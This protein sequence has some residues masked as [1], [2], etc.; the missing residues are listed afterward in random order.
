MNSTQKITQE[1]EDYTYKPKIE[2]IKA[3]KDWWDRQDYLGYMA[4]AYKLAK[5]RTRLEL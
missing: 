4:A 1:F 2:Q 3:D 5:R